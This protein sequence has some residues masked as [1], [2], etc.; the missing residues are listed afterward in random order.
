MYERS[1]TLVPISSNKPIIMSRVN[2]GSLLEALLTDESD[3]LSTPG[4]GNER[5]RFVLNT[6]RLETAGLRGVTAEDLVDSAGE[7][8][9]NHEAARIMQQVVLSDSFKKIVS[10][11]KVEKVMRETMVGNTLRIHRHRFA[12]YHLCNGAYDDRVPLSSV[13]KN[14]VHGIWHSAIF[15]K[16]SITVLDLR[17][18]FIRNS[19]MGHVLH[20]VTEL[21]NVGAVSHEGLIVDL[22]NN[23]LASGKCTHLL[24]ILAMPA[25]KFVNICYTSLGISG[26]A[27]LLRRSEHA[28]EKL[29]IMLEFLLYRTSLDYLEEPARKVVLATHDAFYQATAD[30]ASPSQCQ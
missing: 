16:H 17:S 8:E 14:Y 26:A 12:P 30:P 20:L 9:T 23:Q 10:K 11:N 21:V 5:V 4:T 2:S 25:V 19:D 7:G 28:R 15:S 1:Y 6:T 24:H 29:V 18:L 22:S 3:L 13:V 27:R